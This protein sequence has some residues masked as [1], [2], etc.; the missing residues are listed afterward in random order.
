MV[1]QKLLIELKDILKA[2]YGLN[3]SI[4]EVAEIASNLTGYFDLLMKVDF[5]NKQVKNIPLQPIKSS[6]D[7]RSEAQINI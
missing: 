6:V 4:G 5:E 2:D 3:L 1:S 7:C